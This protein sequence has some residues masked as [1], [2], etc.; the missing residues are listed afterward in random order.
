MD[1]LHMKAL[2]DQDN[3]QARDI[4]SFYDAHGCEGVL[5]IRR[6]IAAIASLRVALG[7]H[8]EERRRRVKVSLS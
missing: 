8:L 6:T 7:S 5:R 3:A 4:E 1:P 2:S